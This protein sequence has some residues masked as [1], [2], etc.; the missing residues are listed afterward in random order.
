MAIPTDPPYCLVYPTCYVRD[1]NPDHF[2]THNNPAGMC[3]HHCVCHATL[4]FSN[5]E[6]KEHTNYAGGHLILP[7]RAQ[8]NDQLFP[9]ILEPRNHRGPLIDSM[10]GEPYPMEMVGDLGPQTQSLK[11]VMGTLSCISM[12]TCIG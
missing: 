4:Q 6:P 10:M 5:D 8:Y 11:D 7:P 9:A 1:V 12:L 2:D 3:L